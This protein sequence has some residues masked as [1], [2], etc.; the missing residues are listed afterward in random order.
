MTLEANPSVSAS[1]SLT[2]RRCSKTSTV[3]ADVGS[4][5]GSRCSRMTA[6]ARVF[7]VAG[8]TSVEVALRRKSVLLTSA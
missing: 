7:I 4:R 2:A 6:H 5:Q 1:K 8:H 3:W